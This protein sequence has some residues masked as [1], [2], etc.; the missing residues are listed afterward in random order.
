MGFNDALGYIRQTREMPSVEWISFSGGEPFLFPD[1]LLKL[2]ASASGMGLQTECVSNCFWAE[3]AEGAVK[4]LE[5]FKKAG[6]GVINISIDDFHQQHL[7]FDRVRNGYHAA[8]HLGIKIVIMSAVKKSSTITAGQLGQLLGDD[9]I[10]ILRKGAVQ[11]ASTTA[12]AVQSSFLPI[13]RGAG[14][15]EKEWIVEDR[16]LAGTCQIV[17]RDISI[18]PTGKVFP[19]CSAAGTAETA[20][21]GNAKEAGLHKIIREAGRHPFFRVLSKKGPKGLCEYLHLDNTGKPYVNKCHLCHE[22]FTGQESG[23]WKTW[24]VGASEFSSSP[25]GAL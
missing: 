25:I 14:I 23:D 17:L 2:I 13:G 4:V 10:L 6:L 7:P 18:H 24:K 20:V 12:L 22:L 21:I 5:R 3:T 11:N 9:G 15:P 8:K 19:C 1:L 16:S